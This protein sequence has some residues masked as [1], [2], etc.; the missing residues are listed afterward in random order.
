MHDWYRHPLYSTKFPKSVTM[1]LGL[2]FVDQM[3][4]KP[5]IIG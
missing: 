3:G 5:T 2:C 1:V 4:R